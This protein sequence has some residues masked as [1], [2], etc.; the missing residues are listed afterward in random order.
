M[1]KHMRKTG[2]SP[3]SLASLGAGER[4]VIHALNAGDRF[5]RRLLDLGFV[6]GTVVEA[7]RRSPF[8]DP[9]AVS[10]RGTTIALRLEDAGR[11]AIRRLDQEP[12]MKGAGGYAERR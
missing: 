2:H 6:P 10:V 8:G 1:A 5:R 12:Q 9:V 4:A 11:I 3:E 7:V